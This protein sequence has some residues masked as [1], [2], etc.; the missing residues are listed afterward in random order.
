M[1]EIR[2]PG[3]TYRIKGGLALSMPEQLAAPVLDTSKC[4]ATC[5]IVT[6]T[7]DR[8]GE[9]VEPTG[10]DYENFARNPVVFFDHRLSYELPI[11]MA[12]E[13]PGALL[14]VYPEEG[15]VV[16]HH[17]FDQNDKTSMQMFRC[18]ENGWLNGLSI[19][20]DPVPGYMQ[21]IG[22][23]PDGKGKAYRYLR[24]QDLEHSHTPLGVNPE[25]LTIAVQKGQVGGEKMLPMIIKSFTAL[26]LPTPI[27]A[28]GWT[29]PVQKSEKPMPDKEKEAD[30]ELKVKEE[31]KGPKAETKS[32]PEEAPEEKKGMPKPSARMGMDMIQGLHDMHRHMTDMTGECEHEHMLK[33]F[34][35]AKAMVNEAKEHVE[36]ALA[37]HHPEVKM[38]PPPKEE[39]KDR[40]VG[41]ESMEHEKPG[42]YVVKS[43]RYKPKR[44]VT[45][46]QKASKEFTALPPEQEEEIRRENLRIAYKLRV[47][48][49]ALAQRK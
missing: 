32:E 22:M 6:P 29:P 7:L 4:I 34:E 43:H 18:I 42:E 2:T 11:A 30:K 13:G 27:Q 31:T 19:G 16:A 38:E 33:A 40:D 10:G 37:E 28:N 39:S 48:E 41:H 49:T 23:R 15:R 12:R 8:Q 20:F 46:S 21:P 44:L 3:W 36:G 1:S 9:I 26:S 35:H 47:I 24:W 17:Y 14:S 45:E 5:A 25:T